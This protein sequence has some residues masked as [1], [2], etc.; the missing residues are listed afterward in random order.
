MIKIRFKEETLTIGDAKKIFGIEV[1]PDIDTLKKIYKSLSMKNHPDVGGS[2]ET[3]KRINMAYDILKQSP[4]SSGETTFQGQRNT[5]KADWD[6]IHK[7][8]KEKN[9]K[10]YK[11]MKEIFESNFDIDKLL[12][13]ISVFYKG[14]LDYKITVMDWDKLSNKAKQ[15]SMFSFVGRIIIFNED[16]TTYFYLNYDIKYDIPKGGLSSPEVDENDIIYRVV[17]TT[18]ILHNNRKHKIFASDSSYRNKKVKSISDYNI[19]YPPIKMNKIFV[20]GKKGKFTKKDIYVIL[21]RQY[22]AY[23]YD[24]K[25]I[26]VPIMP[27]DSNVIKMKT[28]LRLDRNVMLRQGVYYMRVEGYDTNGKIKVWSELGMNLYEYESEFDLFFDALKE[29][30]KEL[31]KK[32]WDE[33]EDCIKIKDYVLSTLKKIFNYDAVHNRLENK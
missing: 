28:N 11:A 26:H 27:G 8:W 24:A 1:I 10:E 12:A 9:E 19:V 23:W 18:N 20:Q 14:K 17:I 2:A 7:W 33:K 15:N 3:M 13:H 25:M 16:K 32:Q 29:I 22:S 6:K 4:G 21:N 30:R 5:N 31:S